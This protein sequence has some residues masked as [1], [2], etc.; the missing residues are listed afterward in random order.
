MPRFGD[1]PVTDVW[2]FENEWAEGLCGCCAN[3]GQCMLFSFK[4]LDYS[5]E[6]SLA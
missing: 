5:H 4:A 3:R 1:Q 6:L 2:D